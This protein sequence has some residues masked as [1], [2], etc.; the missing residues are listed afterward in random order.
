MDVVL[1]H[2]DTSLSVEEILHQLAEQVEFSPGSVCISRFRRTTRSLNAPL[3]LVRITCSNDSIARAFLANE[4][5]KLNGKLCA[6]ELPRANQTSSA[7]LGKH[8]G[9]PGTNLAEA[10][11]PSVLIYPEELTSA[12]PPRLSFCAP[13]GRFHS[14]WRMQGEAVQCEAHT[15]AHCTRGAVQCGI[16]GKCAVCV[17]SGC[18]LWPVLSAPSLP[19][20]K[21]DASLQPSL[22]LVAATTSVYRRIARVEVVHEDRVLEIG[23]DLGGT[24]ALLASLAGGK[25]VG[26]DLSSDSVNSAKAT[27]PR[28]TFL[29]EDVLKEGALRRLATL[30][31]TLGWDEHVRMRADVVLPFTKVFIDINGNR[32]ADTV[33]QVR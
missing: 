22:I 14:G 24:C 33:L 8:K 1:R 23:S 19:F 20:T 27:Y 6:T 32:R 28:I 13:R 30:A 29:Q 26:V 5:I 10:M 4:A 11:L 18:T 17:P 31:H 2:V 25:V 3:P 7:A 16:R 21:P 9:T 15:E 12:W